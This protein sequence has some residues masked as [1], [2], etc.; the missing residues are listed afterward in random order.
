MKASERY[1]NGPDLRMD[2]VLAA[3]VEQPAPESL[4]SIPRTASAVKAN[5]QVLSL[6]RRLMRW[7]ASPNAYPLKLFVVSRVFFIALTYGAL[8]LLSPGHAAQRSVGVNV[9]SLLQAWDQRDVDFYLGIASQGYAGYRPGI[10]SAFFPLMPFA[11]RIVAEPLSLMNEKYA[12][13]AAGMLVSNAAF[14]GAAWFF[15]ALLRREFSTATAQRSLLYLMVFPKALFTFAAYSE[16]LFLLAFIGS[17]YFLRRKQF[18][19]A[20]FFAGLAT[21]GRFFGVIL[22]LPFMVELAW[23]CRKDVRQWLRH[24]WSLLA[25]PAALAIYMVHLYFVLGNALAFSQAE[26]SFGRHF[27]EPVQT[28]LT[29]LWTTRYLAFGSS[30]QLDRVFDLI[31]VIVELALL[32]VALT[33]WGLRRFRLPLSLMLLSLGVLLIPL[34]DPLTSH[35]PAYLYS[36]SRYLLPAIG[37]YA[38][39][40]RLTE[41]RPRWHEAILLFSIGFLALFTIG[42]VLGATVV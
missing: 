37:F 16:G 32:L 31:M 8:S 35:V 41:H 27:V 9:V 6:W 2:Q 34:S 25:I 33:P 40:A 18:A 10:S 5:E 29:A 24:G 42:F 17:Y 4:D 1:E 20:G 15:Y 13:L 7:F 3:Q 36:T 26:D 21:L 11:T 30:L 38:A 22:V 12:Y 39:L 28:L 23:Y 14:F 19:L